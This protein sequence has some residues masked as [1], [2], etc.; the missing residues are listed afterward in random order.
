MFYTVYKI[1]R[2]KQKGE[3]NSQF[4][5]C[6][7]NNGIENKKVVKNDVDKWIDLGYTKG[8]VIARSSNR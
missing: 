5:T 8:R 7:I 2:V 1:M 6:W 3:L 4:G